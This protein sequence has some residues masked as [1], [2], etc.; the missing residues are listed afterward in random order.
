MTELQAE[1]VALA[2]DGPNI[3]R[4]RTWLHDGREILA[5]HLSGDS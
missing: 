2:P 3:S 5:Q 4:A 1:T